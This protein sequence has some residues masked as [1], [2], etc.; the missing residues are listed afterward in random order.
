MSFLGLDDEAISLQWKQAVARAR[1]SWEAQESKKELNESLVEPLT[2]F[3]MMTLPLSAKE[4]DDLVMML[5]SYL[6]RHL[7]C[8]EPEEHLDRI[9]EGKDMGPMQ[10]FEIRLGEH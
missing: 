1:Q 3:C 7:S 5:G 10:D 2:K 6:R 8:D 4:M 9:L